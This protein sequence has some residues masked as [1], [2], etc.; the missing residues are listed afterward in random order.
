MEINFDGLIGPTHN[1]SGLSPGNLASASHSQQASYPKAAALQ[2]LE[3]MRR[4][5][6][7]GYKQGILLPQIRPDLRVLQQ[8]GFSG[9]DRQVI[10][11]VAI[12]AP[13]LLAMVY[14]ASS[15][16]A[17]NAATVTPSADT[18]DGKVHITVANLMSTAHRSIEAPQTALCLRTLF[19]DKNHFTVH[20]A[21]FSSTDF[22]DEGAANHNR[23]C[24]A[25]EQPGTGLFVYGQGETSPEKF[26]A[27]QN[28]NASLAVARQHGVSDTAV[29]LQQNPIAIDAGAFHNDVV[30]VANGPVLFHHELAFVPGQLEAVILKLPGDIPFRQILVADD[31]VSLEEAISSYLFNSQLLASPEGAM[32]QMHLLAPM[33]CKE[34][35]P[36]NRYLEQLTSDDTQPIRKV[37]FVDVR[38]SM[39]NGGGPACLRL[40]VVLN[41]A[42]VSAVDPAFLLDESR[43]DQLVCW[44]EKHYRDSIVPGDLKDPQLLAESYS[45]LTALEQLL[46]L[47]NYYQF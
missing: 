12:Q 22:G 5:I 30:A 41:E 1:Y 19:A 13:G 35:N 10:N 18:P 39:S 21:I 28:L 7:L 37:T 27:R 29:F 6:A 23:L 38:Q 34:S 14:S 9:T 36:V 33:E 47:E 17:A 16:W 45:A 44:V 2:G 40:R 4:L 31:Q 20:D 3:K 11:K 32:D 46:G 43:L 15:M 25:Y 26:P 8:L 42:E 24:A